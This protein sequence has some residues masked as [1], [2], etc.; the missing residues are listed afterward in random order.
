MRS[1]TSQLPQPVGTYWRTAAT[2]NIFSANAH[3]ER[4]SSYRHAARSIHSLRQP[5]Y[6][7]RHALEKNRRPGADLSS[8]LLVLPEPPGFLSDGHLASQEEMIAAMFKYRVF[9]SDTQAHL[10][11]LEFEESCGRLARWIRNRLHNAAVD[12]L[13]QAMRKFNLQVQIFTA[14]ESVRR[15]AAGHPSH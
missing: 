6:R 7:A 11:R 10:R 4:V 3:A 1:V 8:S 14:R 15:P 12:S 13:D 2:Y 5:R 9:D